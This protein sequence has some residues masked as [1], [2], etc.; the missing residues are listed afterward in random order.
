MSL[1]ADYLLERT[2][3][4]IIENEYGFCTYRFLDEKTVYII[5]IYVV[6]ECRRQKDASFMANEVVE[7]AKE[8]GCTELLGTVNPSAKGS[9]TSMRVLLGYGMTLKRAE[10]NLIVFTKEI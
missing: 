5:D 9:T 7:I 1:Y 8:R 3:D 10:N 6:P 4:Q 2:E